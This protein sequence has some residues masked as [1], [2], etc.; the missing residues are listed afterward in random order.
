MSAPLLVLEGVTK[1]YNG[2]PVLRSVD[3]MLD[4]GIAT[5]LVGVNGAGKSTLIRAI[6]DLL[7]LDSGT[8]RI[9]NIPH[10][11]EAARKS[12][13]YLPERFTAPHYLTG[14][15]LLRG[16]LSLHDVVFD[17]HAATNEC[18]LLDL[19]PAVLDQRTRHYSKGMTQKLGLI[20]CT[21]SKCDLLLLDEPLSGLDPVA[22]RDYCDRLRKLKA[23]GTTLF[24]STHALAEV[25]QICDRVVVMHAGHIAFDG[26]VA[27]LCK[28]VPSGDPNAALL[29]LIE[30]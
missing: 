7:A 21:L 4:R 17:E 24:F 1:T 26:T 28:G 10:Q 23:G 14:R 9:N 5:A 12:V 3:F 11:R 6:L 29:A 20:A 8:I 22:N 2:K 15:E 13:A 30:R 25:A 27:A 18:R 16:L 19:D